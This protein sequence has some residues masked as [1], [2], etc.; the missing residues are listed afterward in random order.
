MKISLPITLLIT[1][2]SFTINIKQVS[3]KEDDDSIV[4]KLQNPV[5]GLISVPIQSNWDFGIGKTEAMRYTANV[6]PV[7][8]F[9]LTKDWNLITRTIVPFIHAE[10]TEPDG[11]NLGGLGDI[12]QS[13]F[14]AP[15]KPTANKIIWGVGP[16]FAYPTASDDRLGSEKFGIG[17]AGVILQQ[18]KPWTYG[19]Q[20]NQLWSVAGNSHRPEYSNLL[21]NPFLS[22]ATASKTTFSLNSDTNYD[23]INSQWTVALGTGVNQ[24]VR[25]GKQPVNFGIA[26][27]YYAKALEGNADWALRFQMSFV[28][29]K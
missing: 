8:P 25:F 11:P 17:P 21:L 2:L 22:Y 18:N 20:V 4:Q 7:I 26:V 13:F 5:A 24:L 28:F 9:E 12:Q 6:Q 16:I 19:L 10:A 23:W 1:L 15:V 27:R 14:F 3:A 29:A